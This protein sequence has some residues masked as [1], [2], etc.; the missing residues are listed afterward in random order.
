MYIPLLV[1]S[2]KPIIPT[3]SPNPSSSYPSSARHATEPTPELGAVFVS[4]AE[5]PPPRDGASGRAHGEVSR[6]EMGAD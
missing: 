4:S 2:K 6:R 3:I 1:Y 5:C